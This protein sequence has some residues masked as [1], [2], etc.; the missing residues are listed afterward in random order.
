MRTCQEKGR[1][2]RIRCTSRPTRKETERKIAN[3]EED[4]CKR[5]MGLKEEDAP[6]GTK[7][8]RDIQNRSGDPR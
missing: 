6:D 2:T 3:E 1:R 8:K 7:L 4:S 5:D